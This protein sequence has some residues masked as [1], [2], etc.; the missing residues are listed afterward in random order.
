MLTIAAREA[1]GRLAKSPQIVRGAASRMPWAWDGLVF[2]LP[3]NV[4]GNDGLREVAQD[5]APNATG[6]TV[7]WTEDN[8]GNPS[9]YLD[10]ASF[11]EWPNVPSHDKPSTELTVHVRMIRDSG[12]T[13]S[14]FGGLFSN[15]YA[16][17]LSTWTVYTEGATSGVADDVNAVVQVNGVETAVS[18]G[19][20]AGMSDTEYNNLFLRWRS[21]WRPKLRLYDERGVQ[22]DDSNDVTMSAGSLS[23]G[24]GQGIRLNRQEASYYAGW[25]SQAMVWSR[26]LT[27][28]EVLALM[29]DPFGWYAPRR[30]TLVFGSAFPLLAGFD[31]GN[32]GYPALGANSPM[33]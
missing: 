20:T 19:A 31:A 2:A 17:N 11:V 12:A 33:F 13:T 22:I 21:G 25:Y 32:A 16:S 15:V 9:V 26:Y 3:L 18:G 7:V 6:G 14:T 29:Q 24:G 8:R 28:T 23:Y 1:A 4:P 27:D 10:G 5:L 30:E